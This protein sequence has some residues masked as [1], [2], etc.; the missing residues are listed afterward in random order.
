M[1]LY[2]KLLAVDVG[3]EGK[4]YGLDLVMKSSLK[5]KFMQ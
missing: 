4:E 3:R 2:I 1:Q 5:S